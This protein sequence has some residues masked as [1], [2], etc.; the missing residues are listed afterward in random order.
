MVEA[1]Q[2]ADEATPVMAGQPHPLESEDVEQPD[3]VGLGET[4]RP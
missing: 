1:E 3:D 4:Y 2:E